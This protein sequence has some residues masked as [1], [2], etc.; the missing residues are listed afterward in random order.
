MLLCS[1][2][3]AAFTSSIGG[4]LT[5]AT[6]HRTLLALAFTPRTRRFFRSSAITTHLMQVTPSWIFSCSQHGSL[7]Y[8]LRYF[9]ERPDDLHWRPKS[10]ARFSQSQCFRQEQEVE[11]RIK[12]ELLKTSFRWTSCSKEF[13]SEL[14][15]KLPTTR[16]ESH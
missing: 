14:L 5:R 9:A 11:A 13:E 15:P 8:R 7:A 2:Y 1:A 6:P 10:R 16:P 4:Y 3:G 12:A